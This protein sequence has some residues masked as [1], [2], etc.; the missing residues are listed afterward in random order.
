MVLERV[1]RITAGLDDVFEFFGDPRNLERI[2]PPW[3]GFEI[4][5]MPEGTLKQGHRITYRIRLFTFPVTWVTRIVSWKPGRSFEDLQE[6]GPYAFW[7]HLHTFEE[8][9]GGVWMTDRVEYRTPFGR[10]GWWVAGWWGKRRL[11]EIFDYREAVIQDVF[12]PK[13]EMVPPPAERV[14]SLHHT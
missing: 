8:V 10:L 4:V 3:L 14:L 5:S 2:T 1:T 13:R 11:D 12:R 7:L 6:K 9:E